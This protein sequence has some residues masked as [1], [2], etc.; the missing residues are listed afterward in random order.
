M[1]CNCGV[2]CFVYRTIEPVG[3]FYQ[4]VLI[5]KCGAYII[6]GK[7]KHKCNFYNKKILKT[8]IV[9]DS[10]VTVKKEHEKH[11]LDEHLDT[12]KK[13]RKDIEW[14]IHLLK[15]AQVY[16]VNISNYISLIN[17]NL[18]K[19]QYKPFFIDKESIDHLIKRL[20][21]NPDDIRK[22]VV[23]PTKS[24]SKC[25]SNC[26]SKSKK[27][28]T[29]KKRNIKYAADFINNLETILDCEDSGDNSD[30]NENENENENDIENDIEIE[31]NVS[32]IDY[33]I[34]DNEDIEEAFSD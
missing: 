32:D 2:N 28:T 8:G 16:P 33:D 5:S 1:N 9:I 14:N 24:K 27:T 21:S 20:N 29:N 13:S 15:I 31:N 23:L 25:K 34:F 30:E 10:P 18:K 6:D 22:P 7:R 4:K 11:I 3:N 17:Y 19:L 12:I 26:K